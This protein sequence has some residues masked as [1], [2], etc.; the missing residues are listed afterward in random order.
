[1]DSSDFA[2]ERLD[3]FLSLSRSEK[4][5]LLSS[6]SERPSRL[7]HIDWV[8]KF[9]GEI[10]DPSEPL[11]L[12]HPKNF[13]RPRNQLEELLYSASPAG[14]NLV[15]KYL[16]IKRVAVSESFLDD[17]NF[18]TMFFPFGFFRDVNFTSY[19]NG[20]YWLKGKIHQGHLFAIFNWSSTWDQWLP[21]EVSFVGLELDLILTLGQ[22]IKA[23]TDSSK[24]SNLEKHFVRFCQLACKNCVQPGY[25]SVIHP[26]LINKFLYK[27]LDDCRDIIPY[28]E[29]L[30]VKYGQIFP[31]PDW[32]PKFYRCFPLSL[33]QILKT[34]IMC[35]KFRSENFQIRKDLMP[36]ILTHI[37]HGFY[38][39]EKDKLDLW[40]EREKFY[41]EKSTHFLKSQCVKHGIYLPNLS[42]KDRTKHSNARMEAVEWM[43]AIDL[44]IETAKSKI[45]CLRK[46]FAR[47]LLH[48]KTI[49]PLTNANP[50]IVDVIMENVLNSGNCFLDLKYGRITLNEQGEII[51][52]PTKR[53]KPV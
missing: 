1:M 11:I 19:Y 6:R 4:N 25:L 12:A 35:Q 51:Q 5:I 7:T 15:L 49:K 43:A 31:Y 18:A 10:I 39:H 3:H 37:I 21:N 17:P 47:Q 23:V 40:R 52:G 14:I 28:L 27:F 34:V 38:D 20:I 53:H 26:S 22:H 48:W 9:N 8:I 2:K 36:I 13:R 45:S 29:E 46:D 42:S 41:D 50:A 24:R 33:R 32:N 30:K 44:D 16:E